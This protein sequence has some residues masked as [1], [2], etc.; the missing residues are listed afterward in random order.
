MPDIGL[1]LLIFLFLLESIYFKIAAHFNIIDKP[2]ERSSH[3]TTTIRG[4]GIIFPVSAICFYLINFQ[5]PLFLVGLVLISAISFLDDIKTLCNRVRSFVHLISLSF[6]LFQS[7]LDLSLYYGVLIIILVIGF[8][9]AYNF[10]DGINGITGGYSLIAISSLGYINHSIIH[11]TSEPLLIFVGLNLLI[12]NFFNFRKIA[13]CF[14]S[15]VAKFVLKAAEVGGTYNLADGYYP[16]FKEIS[17]YIAMKIGKKFVPDM[18]MFFAK[19]LAFI[20]DRVW[21]KFPLNSDKLN[22]ITSSLTFDDS[23]ARE[24]F[25]CNPT[26]VLK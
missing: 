19:I 7:N 16:N 10:M 18:P 22:K 6:L 24:A 26:S 20:G 5:Y 3:T 15:D 4:G 12:F 11:F 23:K 13:R 21:Q 8:I 14:A 2:N 25:G 1:Y 17:Q 9:N